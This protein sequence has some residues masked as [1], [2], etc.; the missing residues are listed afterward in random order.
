MTLMILQPLAYVTVKITETWD[1]S[2]NK[3]PKK[4]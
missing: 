4:I 3:F 2:Q 1:K